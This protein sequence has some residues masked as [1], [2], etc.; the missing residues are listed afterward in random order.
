MENVRAKVNSGQSK[1]PLFVIIIAILLSAVLLFGLVY[2]II[3]GVRNLRSA[4]RYEGVYIDKGELNYLASSF[5][6]S[7]LATLKYSGVGWAVDSPV[8]WGQKMEDSDKT[9]GELLNEQ[10]E[11]YIRAVAV[12]AALFDRNA[13][14]TDADKYYLDRAAEDRIAAVGSDAEYDKKAE[15]YGFD[16]KDM[17][18][19]V[20]LIYKARQAQSVIY[21]SDGSVLTLSD[22]GSEREEFLA[23]YTHV[24]LL[25]ISTEHKYE[26]NDAGQYE[27]I[28][29]TESEREAVLADIAKIR[30]LTEAYKT[31][32]EFQM[33]TVMFKDYESKYPFIP[34]FIDGGYYFSPESQYS[35][36]F[37]KSY[38]GVVM[39]AFEMELDSYSEVEW[40]EGACFIYKYEVESGAYG[41]R[42]NADFFGD[43]YENASSYFYDKSVEVLS[44]AVKVK[45]K[46]YDIDFI[47]LSYNYELFARV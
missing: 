37:E 5:K 42:V 12:G 39:R 23:T 9:Y 10:T 44:G 34:E 4:V 30:E 45:D 1:R 16:R 15:P 35:V 38:P 3:I 25:F 47:N 40:S 11:S 20:E 6:Y 31:G 28:D 22:Y 17:R 13:S 21:G 36:D 8:F 2:G 41:V 7:F 46:F 32:A 18:D 14:L 43:F 26:K 33:S 27:E 29:L 24:R 19:A